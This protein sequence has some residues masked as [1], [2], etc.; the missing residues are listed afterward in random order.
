MNAEREGRVKKILFVI[1]CMCFVCSSAFAKRN[2]GYNDSE[3]A[4]NDEKYS[5]A[6]N[7]ENRGQYG[8]ALS[9]YLEVEKSDTLNAS[10]LKNIGNCYFAL[11]DYGSALKYYETFQR[12][13]GDE[14]TGRYIADLKAA[15]KNKTNIYFPDQKLPF[16]F[17]SPGN[18]FIFSTLNPVPPFFLMMGYGTFYAKNQDQEWVLSAPNWFSLLALLGPA[19]FFATGADQR[20]SMNGLLGFETGLFCGLALLTDIFSSPFIAVDNSLKLIDYLKTNEIYVPAE[21]LSYKDPALAAGLSA[22]LPGAGHFYAGDIKGGIR[23]AIIGTVLPGLSI[24]IGYMTQRENMGNLGTMLYYGI[25][26]FSV[27]R[28]LDI[29]GSSLYCDQNNGLYY[30]QLLCKNSPYKV[31]EKL[32]IKVPE[33]AFVVSCLPVPGLGHLYSGNNEA[34]ITAL[35]FGTAGAITFF[36]L[37][38]SNDLSRI[39]KY[40]GLTMYAITKL[41]EMVTSPGYTAI[42]NAVYTDG[43]ESA[44]NSGSVMLIP[45]L[46]PDGAGLNVAYSF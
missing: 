16:D 23:S 33:M 15:L 21:R 41:Y 45:S 40:S 34:A 18:T 25:I 36:C 5:S 24:L 13:G 39:L 19:T 11:K 20:G 2:A 43:K 12:A 9:Q 3:T 28:F 30:R 10:V 27:L 4:V 26:P 37:D 35:V 6:M 7:D 44:K 1:I 32:E 29:L 46:M 17:K 31:T 22:L 42:Y 38:E 14:E 8:K